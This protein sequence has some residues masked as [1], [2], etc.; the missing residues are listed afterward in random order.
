MHAAP[1]LPESAVPGSLTDSPPD[2]EVVDA[3]TTQIDVA[4]GNQGRLCDAVLEWTGSEAVAETVSW[5]VSVPIKLALIVA[6]ALVAVKL[7]RRIIRRTMHR[8][9]TATKEH[10][11]GVLSTRSADRAEERA[12]AVGS[13]LR[14]A[15]TAIIWTI[16]LIMI[17]EALGVS[18]IPVIASAGV[19]SLAIGFG[20]QSLVE[21]LLVGVFM[22]AE[23]QFGIG[24]R[25][26]VGA[27]N[28]TVERVTLRTVV[29]RD[30][31]GNLWHVPN[32]EINWVANESQVRSRAT[33]EIGVAYSTDL[34][35]AMAVLEKAAN[36]LATDPEWEE[37]I[38]EDPEVQGIQE[39]T[40]DAVIVRVLVWVTA[41]ERRRFERDLRLGLKDALEQ[42][43]IEMPNRQLDVWLHEQT[44]AA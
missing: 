42:A 9:A 32:S 38:K 22:L 26:S 15:A 31:E 4:C 8:V 16:A 39:L 24:D 34:R 19:L 36:E 3:V 44:Q 28:G 33:V 1:Q 7:A 25:I 14:S 30:P 10:G 27:V 40:D 43:E 20:A 21:D 5:I 12:D 18:L 41:G 37:H 2:P 17:F 35:E 6:L 13:L 29:I 23:D 11:D